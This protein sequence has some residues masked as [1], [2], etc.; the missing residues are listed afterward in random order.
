MGFLKRSSVDSCN[1]SSSPCPLIAMLHLGILFESLMFDKR[2]ST[3]AIHA[4]K[5][6]SEKQH[7]IFTNFAYIYTNEYG[8][9]S[10][11][12]SVFFQQKYTLLHK[13]IIKN[14]QIMVTK[15]TPIVSIFILSYII[16]SSLKFNAI[17]RLIRTVSTPPTH[18][19][20]ATES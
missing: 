18:Q 6:N 12:S 1:F 15:T 7:C 8:F 3:K 13:I 4:K 14:A 10:S 11:S 5:R 17:E 19:N 20:T 16:Y 9:S 2:I